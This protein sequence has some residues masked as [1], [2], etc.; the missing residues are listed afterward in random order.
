L[1]ETSKD[2]KE[3]FH[4][5][6]L[7]LKWK[8]RSPALSATLAILLA[9]CGLVSARHTLAQEA[10]QASTSAPAAT[11]AGS[12]AS[13]EAKVYPQWNE[14][15]AAWRAAREREIGAPDGW[16]TLIGMEWLNSGVNSIGAAKDNKIQV[17][18]QAP[19]HFGLITVSGGADSAKSH[20]GKPQS[21]AAP[22]SQPQNAP[23]IQ[24]LSPAGGFPPDLLVDG[25]PAR[26][27]QLT[28]EGP[29]PSVISWHGV[30]IVVL[31]RGGRY[32]VRIKDSGT[33]ARTGFKGLNWYAPD[34]H[35]RLKAVWTPFLPEQIEKIPTIIGTT[36]DLPSPGYAEFVL[37][38]KPYRLQPVLEDPERKI[39]FFILSDVTS[40]IATYGMARYLHT[41]L[42]DHGLDKPGLLVLDFNLLENPPC[43][44][45]SY[46]TCPQPPQQN[47]LPVPLEAGEKIYGQQ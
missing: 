18:A 19:D 29:S 6:M 38:G 45:S 20:K 28:V 9:A 11:P 36:L 10:S 33:P 30:T 27:G 44:Y 46:A 26:E 7:Q 15:L 34:P 17:H 21:D 24:L 8:M 35:F 13:S 22:T 43:A 14:D 47:Q 2:R 23:I 4:G 3:E 41:G 25:K 37:D 40:S 12:P 31:N 32:A 39:L 5:M 16:L 1:K 42:P